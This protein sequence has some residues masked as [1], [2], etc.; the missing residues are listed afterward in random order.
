MTVTTTRGDRGGPWDG[1][2]WDYVTG[3]T[4]EYISGIPLEEGEGW[5]TLYPV[6]FTE[7]LFE[8]GGCSS[9]VSHQKCAAEIRTKQASVKAEGR[10]LQRQSQAK[11]SQAVG[12]YLMGAAQTQRWNPGSLPHPI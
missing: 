3:A 10:K 11:P 4:M 9:R 1:G 12:T 7:T 2:K 8:P 5:G 6:Q